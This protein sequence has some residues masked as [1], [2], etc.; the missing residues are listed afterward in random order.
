MRSPRCC[1]STSRPKPTAATIAVTLER[2]LAEFDWT[3]KARLQG[4]L[5]DGRYHGVAIGC[6]LEG[7]GSGPRENVRLELETD[8]SVSVY[9]G[10]SSV[11]QGVETVFAQIAADALGT[12]DGAHPRR[13]S[14][15]DRLRETGLRLLQLALDRDGRL[16][17]RGGSRRAEGQNLRDGSAVSQLQRARH[18][19][20]R[21]H[22]GRS[23]RRVDLLGRAS[24]PRASRPT[25]PLPATSAPTATA[26]TPRTSRSI[27]RP[28]TW[29]CSTTSRWRTSAASST[30]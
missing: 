8:G 15:L 25:A 13:L 9:V 24:P 28:A 26:R 11:G 18:R 6:Y 5:I 27:P 22:G 16:G 19:A 2:C 10:S 3:E 1:R 7:G 20:R 21:R 4:R 29:R 23:R 12:A 30:R 17:H 14:R